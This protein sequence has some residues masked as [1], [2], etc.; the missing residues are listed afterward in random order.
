MSVPP[1]LQRF[2]PSAEQLAQTLRESASF[3]DFL[4]LALKSSG[5]DPRGLDMAGAR[6]RVADALNGV[7]DELA[8]DDRILIGA[9]EVS[10]RELLTV[11]AEVERERLIHA[12]W[13]LDDFAELK[14]FLLALRAIVRY[15]LDLDGQLHGHVLLAETLIPMIESVER[16]QY[17][18][19]NGDKASDAIT[20]NLGLRAKVFA[21][22]RSGQERLSLNAT[23]VFD[24]LSRTFGRF[25]R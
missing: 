8:L 22:D 25:G 20:R 1:S 24:R 6:Y 9:S 10:L 23:G 4:A 14:E 19:D 11:H 2:L 21:L 5:A 18:L 16:R 17:V 13:R 15:A 3:R 7:R 12:I